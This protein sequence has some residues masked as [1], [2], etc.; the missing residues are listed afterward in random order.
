[1]KVIAYLTDCCNTLKSEKEVSG[2]LYTPDLFDSNFENKIIINPDKCDIH[3]CI[4]C[5]KKQINDVIIFKKI[6]K[7]SPEYQ[8]LYNELKANF[9]K[10]VIKK[11]F[12][13]KKK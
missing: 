6:K 7:T 12:L 10:S 1:M 4:D 3:F 2:L 13:R 9:L 11:S 8:K 5:F